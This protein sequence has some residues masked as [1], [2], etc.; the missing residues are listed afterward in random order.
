MPR[1]HKVSERT[2][3][4]EREMLATKMMLY[5]LRTGSTRSIPLGGH[6]NKAHLSAP[7][8]LSPVSCPFTRR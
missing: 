4:R 7:I 2:V 3:M 5:G 1:K 8:S 6:V